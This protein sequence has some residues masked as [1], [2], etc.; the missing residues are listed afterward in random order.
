MESVVHA[1]ARVLLVFA[2][3]AGCAQAQ[4]AAAEKH[5]PDIRAE[6]T[7]AVIAASPLCQQARAE[8]HSHY[9]LREVNSADLETSLAALMEK[10]DEVVLA[11]WS[12]NHTTA[13]SPSGEDAIQYYD[14]KVLY[15]WKGAHKIGDLLTFAVPW[16]AISCASS[17]PQPRG[18]AIN[19]AT[20]TADAG[21]KGIGRPGPWI[22][23]L[24]QSR[25]GETQLTPGLRPAGGD[26]LQG[27]FPVTNISDRN[28]FGIVPGS[29]E[30]C[31][32]VLNSSH[33]KVE[34]LYRRDPLKEKYDGMQISTLM[35]EV[36]SVADSLGYT[37]QAGGAK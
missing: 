16:G 31:T 15:S 2:L 26:G 23:F 20:L 9:N 14:V 5:V 33:E 1:C 27:L 12:T 34:I 8:G 10:S 37:A 25:D 17:E 7:Q 22:L 18:S 13:I 36:E 3:V 32:A 11:G 6:Q 35:K 4:Q 24:R 21:W 28:C 30:R 29:I 19:A